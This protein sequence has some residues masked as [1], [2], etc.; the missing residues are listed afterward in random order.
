MQLK[1]NSFCKYF[2][3]KQKYQVSHLAWNSTHDLLFSG[4]FEIRLWDLNSE[5]SSIYCSLS[6]CHSVTCLNLF[7]RFM[8]PSNSKN[9]S[10]VLAIATAEGRLLILTKGAQ[11]EKVIDAHNGSICCIQWNHDGTSLATCGEDGVIKIWSRLGMLRTTIV[12]SEAPI[13]SFSWSPNDDQVL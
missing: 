5:N 12:L 3:K 11:L 10:E 8:N 9:N 7:N 6:S 1:L 2:I 13:Y 4:D